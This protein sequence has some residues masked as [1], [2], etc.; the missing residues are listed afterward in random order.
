MDIIEH[1]KPAM[2]III[3]STI[4]FVIQFISYFDY[5]NLLDIQV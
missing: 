3:I 2:Y 1:I 5:S 4:D